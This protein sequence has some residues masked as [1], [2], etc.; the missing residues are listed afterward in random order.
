MAMTNAEKQAEL[1]GR[2]ESARKQVSEHSMF[3]KAGGKATRDE[4][5]CS[6]TWL[7]IVPV[8]AKMVERDN[9]GTDLV[10]KNGKIVF[11]KK[12]LVRDD[13]DAVWVFEDDDT[14]L[15]VDYIEDILWQ[16]R[17]RLEAAAELEVERDA[18]GGLFAFA[19]QTLLGFLAYPS[20]ATPEIHGMMR[21]DGYVA[22]QIKEMLDEW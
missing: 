18:I 16:L 19:Y 2:R 17:N 3:I 9:F 22:K 11:N 12:V 7:D 20:I 1:R 21:N 6:T 5:A 4:V 10:I 8:I 14:S 13:E 15:P